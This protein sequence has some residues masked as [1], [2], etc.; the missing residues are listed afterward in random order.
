MERLVR[1]NTITYHVVASRFL[2]ECEGT[3][4]QSPRYNHVAASALCE[5][6]SSLQ[7]NS[8]QQEIASVIALQALFPRND[9]K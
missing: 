9:I 2:S 6:V 1:G 8:R 7:R 4:K 3:A 5:A